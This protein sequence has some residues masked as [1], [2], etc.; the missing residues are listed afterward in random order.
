MNKTLNIIPTPKFCC[1]TKGSKLAVSKACIVGTADEVLLHALEALSEVSK[2][3]HTKCDEAD[4]LI[5]ADYTQV[6]SD[7]LDADDLKSFDE[8][9]AKLNNSSNGEQ[10]NETSDENK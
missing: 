5:Y 6:P 10:A 7:Y 8:K 9:F 4:L 1:Y 2:I 3:R